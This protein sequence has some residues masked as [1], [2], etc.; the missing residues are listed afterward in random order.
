MMGLSSVT[1]TRDGVTSTVF[2]G[3]DPDRGFRVS[4]NRDGQS[5]VQFM[6][7]V[8]GYQGL[9]G[10]LDLLVEHDVFDRDDVL[11]GLA[12]AYLK[13]PIADIEEPAARIVAGIVA[14][15]T[16]ASLETIE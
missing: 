4:V 16:G 15:L 1:V 6:S 13:H 5:V 10:T 11:L 9:A 12:A 2:Y 7:I 14:D 8:S 3:Y